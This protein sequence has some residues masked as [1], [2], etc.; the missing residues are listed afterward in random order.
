MNSRWWRHS[1]TSRR[2]AVL[3]VAMVAM[4]IVAGILLP[5]IPAA[6]RDRRQLKRQEQSMQAEILRHALIQHSLNRIHSGSHPGEESGSLL[7]GLQED[8]LGQW[9]W[10]VARNSVDDG[11][12][13]ELLISICSTEGNAADRD[14][15]NLRTSTTLQVPDRMATGETRVSESSFSSEFEIAA[16]MQFTNPQSREKN[17]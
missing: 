1:V 15:L 13:I 11:W 2:G 7:L 14:L 12:T 4:V 17:L 6:L 16:R 5:L 8:R 9:Q 3:T 10:D